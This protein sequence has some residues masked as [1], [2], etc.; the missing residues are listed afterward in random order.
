MQE[1]SK[2]TDDELAVLKDI[3]RNVEQNGV[4]PAHEGFVITQRSRVHAFDALLAR[5][6]L[7]KHGPVVFW[8]VSSLRAVAADVP[9]ARGELDRVRSALLKIQEM[10]VTWQQKEHRV[11]E[12]SNLLGGSDLNEVRRAPTVL[13][14]LPVFYTC[15]VW[16]PE[17]PETIGISDRVLRLDASEIF[18]AADS[19]SASRDTNDDL[20]DEQRLAVAARN[21]FVEW[22]ARPYK[23]KGRVNLVGPMR[24][25]QEQQRRA[26]LPH[27]YLVRRGLTE[28]TNSSR[29]FRISDY[30]KDL[31]FR[32]HEI[33]TALGILPEPTSDPSPAAFD[34]QTIRLRARAL[35]E[36]YFRQCDERLNVVPEDKEDR[37]AMR[38]LARKEL[39]RETA[40]GGAFLIGE[41]GVEVCMGEAD[42]DEV[43]GLAPPKPSA[44]S[45]APTTV[46]LFSGP[47]GAVAA[48]P[49]ASAQGTVNVQSVDEALRK[50]VELQDDLGELTD[51]LF[52]LLRAARR[53]EAGGSSEDVLVAAIQDAEEFRNFEKTVKPGLAGA[54]TSAAR[55][56]LGLVSL[57]KPALALLPK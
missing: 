46:N 24:G 44:F 37:A 51:V 25:S 52:P 49:G 28:R 17:A 4:F 40:K 9:F 43:L 26:L 31:A 48:A 41:R 30:G 6:D 13:N 20:A 3:S 14:A 11:A 38:E 5:R 57:L 36:E 39:A 18:D 10:Y 42:L 56:V 16:L 50:V 54:S 47:V 7:I 53:L 22:F 2:F 33:D 21:L 55:T 35:F 32:E 8:S 45:I 12:L 15:G 23:E 34:P 29:I 19:T 1:L 27:E